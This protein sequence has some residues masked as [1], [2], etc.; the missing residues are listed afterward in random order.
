MARVNAYLYLLRNGRP[1]NAAYVTDNDLLPEGHPKSSRALETAETRQVNLDPPAYMRAAARRGVAL[2]EDG[3]AG[4]GV[5]DKTVREARLMIAGSVTADKWVRTRAWIAR[6]LVDLDAPA[7]N[8]E[9]KDYPS[10]GVVAHL[11]WGSGPTKRAAQRT[12]EYAEGVVARIEKENEGRK[13][14]AVTK[15]ETRTI[16]ADI[17]VRQTTT[18]MT[19]TGYAALFDSPSEPLPFTERIAPGA[20]TRSLKLRNDIKMLWNHDSG[21]ILGSTRAGTLQLEQDNRGLRVTAELP[22]TT[23]GKDAQILLQR[24]DIDSMSFGFSVPKDGDEWSE[25]G[26]ER[27]LKSVRLHEVS[28]VAFA[29]YPATSG[30][31]QVRGLDRVAQRAS[32]DSDELAEALIKVETGDDLTDGERDLL[33]TVIDELGPKTKATENPKGDLGLLWLAKKKIDL[34]E[35][36][37]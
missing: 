12:L 13:G 30:T 21:L 20:F 4:D 8:P 26:R 37:Y 7:A 36:G 34:L 28:L 31:T 1:K 11:L 2:Y 3:Q 23:T 5:T 24:G 17:E 25:D 18:G 27:T 6:H 22:Q 15:L 19:F 35:K 29:A 14:S 9:H 32:V 16:V 10:R 33:Q